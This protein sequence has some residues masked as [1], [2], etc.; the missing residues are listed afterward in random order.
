V[1]VD[2]GG[3]ASRT[4]IASASR[5]L[6]RGLHLN[7]A[8][9][10]TTATDRHLAIA[11]ETGYVGVEVR[12]ERLLADPAELR[13]AA[14]GVRPGEVWSLN[15]I[16]IGLRGDGSLDR[17]TL[18]ADL[19]PRLA[20]CRQVGAAYLMAVPPRRAGLDPARA[21]ESVREGLQLARDEAAREGVRLAFEF[22]G[23]FDCPIRTPGLAGQVVDGLDG[24]DLVLDS[25]H[26]HA[27]G[28]TSLGG[29][30]VERLAMVHLN[31]APAGE[32]ARI[33]DADR[34]LPGEGVI[35][36]PQLLAELRERGYRGPFSLETFNPDHWA[37]DPRDIAV[38]GLKALRRLLE[39]AGFA[40]ES[41]P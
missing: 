37:A 41:A 7:G 29:F 26:W 35:R 17:P 16:G 18:E 8:T 21:V 39:R 25:C 12:A 14:S 27:S 30:P 20:V 36:L 40:V 6:A 13:R 2:R 1:T 3:A 34:L 22:L 9:I 38:R 23:F 4:G 28:A 32:P 15:G 5:P 11:R 10:M 31:D 24:V 33:E 19:P